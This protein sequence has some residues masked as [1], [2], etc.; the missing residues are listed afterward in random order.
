MNVEETNLQVP[1]GGTSPAPR[2]RRLRATAIA[3]ASALV[4]GATAAGVWLG[5]GGADAR[6]PDDAVQRSL[7][8]LVDDGFPAAL[9]SV[10]DKQGKVS[11]YA[12]GVADLE[13]KK[14]ADANG[15]VRVGS[16]TKTYTAV[17]VLQLVQEGL[18]EL[19]A[20]IEN[21]LPGLVKGEG[22]DPTKITV[23]HLLQHTSGLPEYTDA[24]A[25]DL[26]SLR[27]VYMSPRTVLDAGL[28]QPALFQ[29]GERW[30]YSNTGYIVLGLLIE[31]VTQRPLGEQVTER[32]VD[33][34]GLKHTYFPQVGER[35]LRGKYPKGYHRDENDKL[36]DI[37][38]LDPSWG[39]AAGQVVATPSDLNL[40]LEGLLDGKLLNE[41]MLSEM[42]TTVPVED[43]WEGAE[44]GLGLIKYPLSCGG[45]IWGHGGDIG[46]YETRNGASVD[47][48]SATVAVTALPWAFGDIEDE[49]A[50]LERAI[51]VTKVIDTAFCEIEK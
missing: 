37:S 26:L 25:G 49:D 31:Q 35:E 15:Y 7:E 28:A 40:F 14:K 24:L 17:V 11:L 19:D 8:S 23:R 16:N 13:T 22:I 38:A 1:E 50:I 36:V 10:T 47:G 48:R 46:G 39:W 12:S 3:A 42:M 51:A 6:T 18:V 29:P 27:D 4:L 34:L 41:A 32:I 21:Y 43:L 9:A 30:E 45:E 44:Y 20:P 33:K 5:T 2:S